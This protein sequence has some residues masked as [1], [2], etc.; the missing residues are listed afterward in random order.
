[1]IA[2]DTAVLSV[3]TA[4]PVAKILAEGGTGNWSADLG[5]VSE[6]EYIALL[7]HAEKP[8]SPRD[9]AHNAVFLVAKIATVLESDEPDGRG[10]ARLF[11]AFSEYAIV[12]GT[13]P[14]P[15]KGT[16]PIWFATFNEMNVDPSSLQFVAMPKSTRPPT[17]GANVSNEFS[18]KV[19]GL[20]FD[21]AK[22]G[23]ALRYGVAK[24]KIEIIL[25]T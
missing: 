7:R 8:N 9:A 17:P 15:R 1:M 24:D 10:K 4:D 18:G 19:S 16:N 3:F 20:S 22:A 23:L 5:R 11:I 14:T 25:R 12:E 13:R 2:R 6:Y 21:E